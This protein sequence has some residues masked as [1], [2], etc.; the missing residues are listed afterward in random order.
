MT[1]TA[2]TLLVVSA[3]LT[4]VALIV[5]LAL[6]FW[7]AAALSRVFARRGVEPWRAWVP[8]L[9][10]AEIL[11]LGG[12]PAWTVVFF[13]IP[14]VNIYAVVLHATAAYRV[15]RT[16]RRGGGATAL[17]VLVPPVWA[18]VLASTRE[19]ASPDAAA[20]ASAHTS[21]GAEEAGAAGVVGIA[22]APGTAPA[23]GIAPGSGIASGI[24]PSP[25]AEQLT[26]TEAPAPRPVHSPFLDGAE[27][28]PASVSAID[29]IRSPF[30]DDPAAAPPPQA[31][32]AQEPAPSREAVTAVA[33]ELVAAPAP[34]PAPAVVP[35]H[36]PEP[37]A[38]ASA[39]IPVPA[40]PPE[41]LVSP[42]PV[43]LPEP[44][45][46][47]GS[48]PTAAPA[49]T[50]TPHPP[51][52]PEPALG[53]DDSAATIVVH[54]PAALAWALVTDAGERYPLE[55]GVVVLGRRPSGD[56][57]GVQY[58][59][60]PDTSRTLS[61]QHACLTLE[62]DR[63]TIADLDST[64]GVFLEVDGREQRV[65]AGES[66]AVDGRLLLGTVGLRIES[67]EAR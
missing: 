7:Y 56:E 39:P 37:L 16:F 52:T 18:T 1:D 13:F 62:G 64:N 20:H 34:A 58:L 12:L 10:E 30:L 8:V 23:P 51:P 17:A 24:E 5:G 28:E 42:E 41:P 45:S 6:F 22:P 25:A 36:A 55:A 11:R 61:K 57:P 44:A 54:R 31:Q 60:V 32:P 59:A 26:P 14:I 19:P 9:N 43:S 35:E 47:A 15:S 50:P 2:A 38:P 4:V 65:V 67:G 48:I 3:V 33:P 27:N 46:A 21:A 66:V 29:P 53:D 49:L 40:T 63:W